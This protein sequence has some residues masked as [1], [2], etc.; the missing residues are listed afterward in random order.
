MMERISLSLVF[1]YL[2][3]GSD[4]DMGQHTIVWYLSHIRKTHTLFNV[5]ADVSRCAKFLT[6]GLSLYL[7][8]YFVY[9]RSEGSDES[10]QMRRLVR[11]MPA[12]R[13]DMY[14]NLMRCPLYC[15]NCLKYS[16][17]AFKLCTL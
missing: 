8:S 10:A 5:H 3:K 1:D 13:Y 14:Q 2:G 16:E 4:D 15:I 7:L 6:F 17:C 12:R 11:A 9:P